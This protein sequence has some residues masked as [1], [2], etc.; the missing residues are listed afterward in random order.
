[1]APETVSHRIFSTKTDVWSF[2]VLLF[3]VTMRKDPYENETPEQV[4]LQ[5]M[6]RTAML[7]ITDPR[8]EKMSNILKECYNY[9]TQSRPDFDQICRFLI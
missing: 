4:L 2:A 3:E 9:D 7:T 8:F 6:S 5:I 1:M